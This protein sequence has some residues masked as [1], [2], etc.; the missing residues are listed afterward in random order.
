MDTRYSRR[1]SRKKAVVRA[2]C[3]SS[4]FKGIQFVE[5]GTLYAGQRSD[6]FRTLLSNRHSTFRSHLLY[7]TAYC[8]LGVGTLCDGYNKGSLTPAGSSPP[9]FYGGAV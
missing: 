4:F 6:R 1:V 2:H 7:S 3:E 9:T 8:K 5:P